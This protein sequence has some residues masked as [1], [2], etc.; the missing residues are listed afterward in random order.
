MSAVINK[1]CLGITDDSIEKDFY[2]REGSGMCRR[3]AAVL[4]LVAPNSS[5]TIRYMVSL[6]LILVRT[7]GL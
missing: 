4:Y 6:S 2:E 1:S 7:W 3:F 5:R